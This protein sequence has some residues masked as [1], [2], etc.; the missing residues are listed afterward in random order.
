M[1]TTDGGLAGRAST[2]PP[3]VQRLGTICAPA[4]VVVVVQLLLFPLPLGMWIQGLTVGLLGALVALGMAL[5]YRAN[6]ILNFAQGDLGVAPAMLSVILIQ[7]FAWHYVAGLVLGLAAALVLGALVELAIIRRF[8]AAPRL[9]LTVAT[10]GLA[11]LLVVITLYLPDWLAWLTG[12]DVRSVEVRGDRISFPWDLSFTID[13][14]IFRADHVVAWIVSPAVLVG[15]AVFLRV[16]TVGIAIRASA[17]RA[18]RASLLGI[19]VKRINTYVWALAAVLSFVGLALRAGIVGLPFGPV[20]S[21]NVLLLALAALTLGKLTDLP[22]IATSAVALGLLEQGV[23]WNDQINLGFATIPS[24]RAVLVTPIIGLVIL[25]AL[26]VQRSGTTRAETDASSSWQTTDD[27]RP[28]PPEVRSVP[29][30]QIVRVA[31]VG[32]VTVGLLVL[33]HVLGAADSLKASAVIIYAII[34]MSLVVL[35]GW[36]GQVSLGQMGFVGIGAAVA[37]VATSQW[38]LDLTLALLVAGVA[39]ALVALLVGLPALRLRGLYLGVV[40]LAFGLATSSYFLNAQ[41]FGWVPRVNERIARPPLLGQ[42]SLDSP[43]RIYYV[44]LG[45]FALMAFVVQG[46]RRSRTGRV[47][48]AMRENERGAQSY[49]V[50][51][52]RAKLTAFA[53]SGF[54]AAFAGGLL[55]HHQQFFT[56]NLVA[57]EQNLLVFTAAVVG[58]LGS[59]LGATLGAL[60]LQGGGWFFPTEFQLL[61]TSVGVLIVLL[62]VPGGLGG[63]V[64]RGRDLWLRSVARRHRIVSPSLLA[65]QRE[66]EAMVEGEFEAAAAALDE[67]TASIDSPGGPEEPAEVGGS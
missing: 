28:V 34:A 62:L 20:F 3:R 2:L 65:D 58:G 31:L 45:G 24:E 18:Q 43:T 53:V 29:E 1:S 12:R 39:G 44:C 33:P 26:L 40:T 23:I 19:P 54:V 48:I 61:A 8:F 41:F 11:Q 66:L 52:V 35:T 56:L 47:L 42:W 67:G 7:S 50:S 38:G 37:A 4:A 32:L 21:L 17:E 22:A 57:A 14:L 60:Y 6:R 36:A 5:V 51:V 30:V 49:G 9:I 64:Y 25:V 16:T 13:P 27:V 15:V 10:I 55:V 63:A 59:I 46:I